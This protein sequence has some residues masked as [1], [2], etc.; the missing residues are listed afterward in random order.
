MQYKVAVFLQSETFK[1]NLTI[2]AL[3]LKKLLKHF[4]KTEPQKERKEVFLCQAEILWK[5]LLLGHVDNRQGRRSLSGKTSLYLLAMFN[6]MQDLHGYFR[7]ISVR[8]SIL[9][10]DDTWLL[11]LFK[12]K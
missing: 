3:T 12:Q 4:F 7:N 1:S 9:L 5:D 6:I 8:T 2:F 11:Y 10:Y